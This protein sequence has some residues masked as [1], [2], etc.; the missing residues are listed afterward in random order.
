LS[1]SGTPCASPRSSASYRRPRR[2]RERGRACLDRAAMRT[3]A[4][5]A[6][7]APARVGSLVT[8]RP[9]P[10]R[11]HRRRVHMVSVSRLASRAGR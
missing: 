7:L 9:F 2:R 1:R 11:T 8:T 3:L 4:G 5:G 10:P 6:T